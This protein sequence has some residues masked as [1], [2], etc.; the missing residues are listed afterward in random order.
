MLERFHID[1]AAFGFF[2]RLDRGHVQ[3]VGVFLQQRVRH[4]CDLPL[5]LHGAAGIFNAERQYHLIFPQRDG[6]EHGSLD[7]FDER[8]VIVLNHADLRRSLQREHA[9][10]F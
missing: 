1:D 9:R 5:S 7:F 4:I 10:E 8:G 3:H 6:V 2:C